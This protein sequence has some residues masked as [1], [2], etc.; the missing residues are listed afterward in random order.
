MDVFHGSDLRLRLAGGAQLHRAHQ[1]SFG[2]IEDMTVEHPRAW[3]IVKAHHEPYG[4]LERD[5]D[6]VFPLHRMH[7]RTVLVE[8]EEEETVEVNGM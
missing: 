4:F 8:D 2:V 7:R 6:G 3:T 5:G 1:S